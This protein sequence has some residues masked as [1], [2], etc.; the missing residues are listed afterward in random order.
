[1]KI[2]FAGTIGRSGLGGQAWANLQYLLG[3]Q[4]L[5]H[6]VWYLEDCGDTSYVWNWGKKEWSYEL[7]YPSAYVHACLAPFGFSERWIYRT[8]TDS[9]GLSLGEFKQICHEADLLIIRSVP[10]WVWHQE[11]DWP[12]RRAFLDADPGFTQANIANGDQGLAGGIARCERRFTIGAKIGKPGCSIPDIGGPWLPTRTPIAL[13][14][15]PVMSGDGSH[16][17]SVIRWQGISVFQEDT[18]TS[19][20]YGQRDREFPKYL[21][22]PVLTPQKFRIALLGAETGDL[23]KHGWEVERGEVVSQTLASYRA[24]IQQSHAEFAVPKHGYIRTQGGWFS[25][26]SVCYLASGRPVLMGETGVSDDIPTGKGLVTFRDLS[27][28]VTGVSQINAD[29]QRHRHAA[30]QLAESY[31]DATKVLPSM[32]EAAMN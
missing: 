20:S 32:L 29:Y 30:R 31:F 15:W 23:T 13:D 14:Q 24:F 11:Y 22:L 6:D 7:D 25:D 1:M 19:Q 8:D 4:A 5:G 2:V 28:A 10:L 18:A 12:R 9:R 27:G 21:A 16:F 3:M 26:R 17:T